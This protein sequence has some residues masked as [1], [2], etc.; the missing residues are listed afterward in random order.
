VDLRSIKLHLTDG[1]A[2][3][4][5][6]DA[7]GDHGRDLEG[8]RFA[9]V[10]AAGRVLVEQLGGA[11]VRALSVDA[12]GRVVRASL[13][14]ARARKLDGADYDV[15][16]PA[17]REL[18][19]AA[20]VEL[21]ASGA[22]GGSPSEREFWEQRYAGGDDRWELGRAAPPLARW[23]ADHPPRAGARALVVG[24]GRGHEARLLA[25]AGARVTAIDF[26][27]A[28]IADARAVEPQLAI[29]YRVQDL[30][31]LEGERFELVVE[32]TC[33]CAIDPARRAEYARV[34]RSVLDDD[35][36]LVALFF[37]HRRPGGPPFGVSRDELHA[38]FSDR[39]A[40]AHE[41]TPRDSVAA[42]AGEEL[43]ARLTPTA[44]AR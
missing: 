3:V 26:A 29:D 40:F 7:A 44:A 12:V 23:L 38:I 1:R 24:C 43:L 5:I 41:E 33:F 8:D 25:R 6:A 2:R 14:G 31:T 16:V 37:T 36:A 10:A 39:F 22:R 15:L 9:R 13:D 4:V 20:L 11:A 34:I 18:A 21:Y 35:G 42:R 17:I 28:A 27:A 30:F 19:R 32:H